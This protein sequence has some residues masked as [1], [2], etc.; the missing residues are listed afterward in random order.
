MKKYYQVV[1]DKAHADI[2]IYGDITS[3]PELESDVSAASL[4]TEID[5][6]TVPTINV[7]INSYGGAVADALAIV[8][9]LER[10]K[11]KVITY[12]DGFACSA[13][14]VIFMAGDERLMSEA[15]VLFIHNAMSYMAGLYNAGELQKEMDDIDTIS[16][17][18]LAVYQKK[19]NIDENELRSLIDAETWILPED[20]VRMGFATGIVQEEERAVASMGARKLVMRAIYAQPNAGAS[21]QENTRQMDAEAFADLVASLVAEKVTAALNIKAE[22]DPKDEPLTIEPRQSNPGQLLMALLNQKEEYPT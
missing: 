11:A 8:S 9:A 6:L 3:Y 5:A 22:Q 16:E 19:V 14:S 7:Y 10:N 13:A 12:C 18:C 15:S 1:G 17:T 20:A 21:A 2:Y 4:V